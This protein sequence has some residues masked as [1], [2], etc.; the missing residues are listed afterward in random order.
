MITTHT[1]PHAIDLGISPIDAAFIL[2]LITGICIP[3]R[4]VIGKFSDILGGRVLAM[5]C[6]LI[7]SL[8]LFWTVQASELWEF[9][10]FGIAFGISW[11]GLTTITTAFVGDIFGTQNIGKIMGVMSAI[12]SS[13]AAIGPALGGFTFDITGNYITAFLTAAVA[14]LIVTILLYLINRKPME[15]LD[16]IL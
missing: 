7:Q 15:H 6:A 13:G 9:Y 1:I 14:M 10:I 11:G 12:W 8:S 4:M 3:A 2:S 5:S 16:T